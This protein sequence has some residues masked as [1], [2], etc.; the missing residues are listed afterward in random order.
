M[1]HRG[2]GQEAALKTAVKKGEK[3]IE[4]KKKDGKWTIRRACEEKSRSRYPLSG[5]P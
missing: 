4:G 5:G 2:E 3:T 1:N